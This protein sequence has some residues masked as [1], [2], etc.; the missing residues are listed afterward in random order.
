MIVTEETTVG[1]VGIDNIA[2]TR[3]RVINGFQSQW[4]IVGF[5]CHL[6]SRLQLKKSNV[7]FSVDFQIIIATIGI[8][9]YQ[10]IPTTFQDGRIF[11]LT[12]VKQMRLTY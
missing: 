4:Y 6:I 12:N 2:P 8:N 5:S 11:K 9:R 1:I 10:I 3:M 7:F